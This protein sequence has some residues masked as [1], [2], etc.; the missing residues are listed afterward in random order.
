MV[1]ARC[2][3]WNRK[4]TSV[5]CSKLRSV[6]LCYLTMSKYSFPSVVVENMAFFKHLPG[7][8]HVSLILKVLLAD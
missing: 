7:T 6:Q 8:K 4:V 5:D 1:K 3:T 2:S